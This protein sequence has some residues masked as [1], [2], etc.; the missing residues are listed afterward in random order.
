M[1]AFFFLAAVPVLAGWLYWQAGCSASQARDIPGDRV[2][3]MWQGASYHWNHEHIPYLAERLIETGVR[4]VILTVEWR[5]VEWYPP[6]RER[7]AV[8][9]YPHMYEG[10]SVN[11]YHSY[12]FSG[13]DA[14]VQRLAD[15]KIQ[16]V[17][18]VL[19]HP[20]WAGG[21][22]AEVGEGAGKI[23]NSHK[24]IFKQSFHDLCANLARRYPSVNHWI[25]WNEPNLPESFSP[26]PPYDFVTEEYMRLVVFPG[27]A[28]VRNNNPGAVFAGPD[29]WTESGGREGE[30]VDRNW[31]GHRLKSKWLAHWTGLLLQRHGRR[32]DVFTVHNYGLDQRGVEQAVRN[33]RQIM[34]KTGEEK[35][36]WVTELNFRNGLCD[37]GEHQLVHYLRSVCREQTWERTFYFCLNGDGNHCC[38]L[39]QKIPEGGWEETRYLFPA[40]CRL[41]KEDLKP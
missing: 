25:I 7:V 38:G 18:K 41:V 40:F 16:V 35:P 5:W 11:G 20:R 4:W 23:L 32:F 39:L 17:F 12:N 10:P 3:V 37:T 24:S 14:I 6:T 9:G 27:Q 31:P 19:A 2:A 21:Q 33:V 29:L 1:P 26:E 22:E 15:E 30:S 34:E 13:L 36:V 8:S 28:G